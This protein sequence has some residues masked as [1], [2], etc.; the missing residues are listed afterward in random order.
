MT[1][2]NTDYLSLLL[3]FP[4]VTPT[5]LL[6]LFFLGMMRV[7]PII[8][9]S[10]FLG[11]RLPGA[12]KMGLIVAITAV[13]LPY[14]ISTSKAPLAFDNFFIAC[15][16]KEVFLGFILAFLAAIPFYIAQSAGVL[17]DFL[18]GSSSLMVTDPTLQNQVSS[19]G[20][21]YNYVL[22]VLFYQIN[23]PFLFFDALFQSY[24]IIPAEGMI[25]PL[26]FSLQLPFWKT[27]VKLLTTVTAISIQL[28]APSLVAILMAEMFLGIANRLAPQVQIAFLGMSIKSFLGIA[29]LCAGWFFILQ[30]LSKFVL[31]WMHEIQTL[32]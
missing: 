12:V 13:I 5:G 29:L 24:T 18:R 20:L 11:A 4:N 2:A 14:L 26:F 21:L 31:S 7:A 1:P 28:S 23:G 9:F 32:L 16:L 22:I 10:P 30:Q 17:I 27:I 19:I 6:I 8:V 15:C 25:N 3:N